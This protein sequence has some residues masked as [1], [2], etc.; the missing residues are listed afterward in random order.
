MGT[1]P[2]MKSPPVQFGHPDQLKGKFMP[3]HLAQ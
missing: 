2:Q 1:W 3:L